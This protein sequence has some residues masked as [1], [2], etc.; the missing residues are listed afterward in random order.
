MSQA[1]PA[2]SCEHLLCQDLVSFCL[3]ILL[4]APKPH[5]TD[6]KRDTGRY[7]DLPKA[8]QLASGRAETEEGL[9]PKTRGVHHPS[10]WLG[11]VPFPGTRQEGGRNRT[12][13]PGAAR[14]FSPAPSRPHLTQALRSRWGSNTP[15]SFG[16]AARNTQAGPAHQAAPAGLPAPSPQA[17]GLTSGPPQ[18]CWLTTATSPWTCLSLA[19]PGHQPPTRQSDPAGTVGRCGKQP[20]WD[21]PGTRV[22]TGRGSP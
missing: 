19:G 11:S 14:R 6:G 10:S 15:K 5:F 17:D 18:E 12:G 20:S 1:V 21:R 3:L 16:N 2:T 7:S 13:Y 9:S 8:T 22:G 4:H